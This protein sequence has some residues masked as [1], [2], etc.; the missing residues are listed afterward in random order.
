MKILGIDPGLARMGWAVVAMENSHKLSALSYGCIETSKHEKEETRLVILYEEMEKIFKKEKP[1]LIS[2]EQLL[3]A[4]NQTTA[5]E[6]AQARGVVCLLAGLHHIP[7]KSVSPT[8]V[9]SALVGYGRAEKH[10]VQLMVKII[11]NLKQIPKPDD[12]ADALAIAYTG[13]VLTHSKL[14][15]Q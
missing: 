10:Q 2:I 6:V 12:T 11:Y 5:F 3:F 15:T 13:G 14:E 1:D 4:S 8:Q 7:V 9:K